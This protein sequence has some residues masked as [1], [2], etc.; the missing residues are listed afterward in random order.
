MCRPAPHRER[1]ASLV[2][3]KRDGEV[4][5]LFGR[6]E[7]TPAFPGGRRART[8]RTKHG[9]G[10]WPPP[11]LWFCGP[12]G[13]AKRRRPPARTQRPPATPRQPR[14]WQSYG[15]CPAAQEG[16]G[17]PRGGGGVWQARR[18]HGAAGPP[19]KIASPGPKAPGS[20]FQDASRPAA[21]PPGRY[22]PH[23]RQKGDG[24]A[25]PHDLWGLAHKTLSERGKTP[26]HSVGKARAH[27]LRARAEQPALPRAT[28]SG[29]PRPLLRDSR[30]PRRA[31]AR[32]GPPPA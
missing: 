20:L 30:R 2:S 24:K 12:F 28:A 3:E 15:G 13:P 31:A 32:E 21:A 26:V 25:R 18:P 4:G 6:L 11:L 1:R 29:R 5:A 10:L 19:N 22:G 27:A 17:G 8:A 16:W 23:Q 14:L 7:R 9:R